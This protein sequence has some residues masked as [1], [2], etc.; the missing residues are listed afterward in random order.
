[1]ALQIAT[2]EENG[3][4]FIVV[5]TLPFSCSLHLAKKVGSLIAAVSGFMNVHNDTKP[6]HECQ[7]SLI[8][9][10]GHTREGN[11]VITYDAA[12][13]LFRQPDKCDRLS[14]TVSAHFDGHALFV[15][16]PA[17]VTVS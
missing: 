10:L 5:N 17:G 4:V 12:P 11:A 16:I 1:V 3:R 14:R 6:M 9:L 2:I 13:G 15:N 7:T 8:V